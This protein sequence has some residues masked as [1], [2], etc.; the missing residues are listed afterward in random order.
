MPSYGDKRRIRELRPEHNSLH[1]VMRIASKWHYLPH[2]WPE[3]FIHKNFNFNFKLH[4]ALKF[5]T[6]IHLIFFVNLSQNDIKHH[7]IIMMFSD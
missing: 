3:G 4:T 5:N 7:A 6:R 2:C 1:S